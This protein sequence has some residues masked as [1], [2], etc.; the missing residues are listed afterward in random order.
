MLRYN[1]SRC[2]HLTAADHSALSR[3]GLRLWTC[4]LCGR[5][6]P[7]GANT[8][9][10]GNIK[11]KNCWQAQIDFVACSKHCADELK[12]FLGLEEYE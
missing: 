2:S 5:I 4:S 10:F 6:S 7:W 8:T 11:C 9:Y 12:W 3:T 1:H